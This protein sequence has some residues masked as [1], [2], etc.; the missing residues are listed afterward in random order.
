MENKHTCRFI[1]IGLT[2]LLVAFIVSTCKNPDLPISVSNSSGG[3]FPPPV[4]VLLDTASPAKVFNV[5]DE[6]PPAVILLNATGNPA[7]IIKTEAPIANFTNFGI[8]EGLPSGSI[9]GNIM[10][11]KGQLWFSTGNYV[12]RYDGSGFALLQ[13]GDGSPITDILEDRTGNYWFGSWGGGVYYYDGIFFKN[14]S[15]KD[16]L[17]HNHVFH[18]MEDRKGNVWITTLG[19]GISRFN[20]GR[21]TNYSKKDGLATDM[22]GAIAEDNIGNIW[23]ST[24]GGGLSRFDGTGFT[25]YTRAQGLVD[26]SIYSIHTDRKGNVWFGTQNGISFFD[27]AKFTTVDPGPGL[28]SRNINDIAEDK[29]GKLWFATLGGGV[30]SYDGSG[31][32]ILTTKQGL[33][34]D[35]I[36]SISL[37]R[38]GNV[39]FGSDGGG[40][41]R[42]NGNAFTSFSS[43][44][45]PLTRRIYG[46]SQDSSGN[47]WFASWGNSVTKFDGKNYTHFTSRQGLA[48]RETSSLLQDRNGNIWIGTNG[49]LNRFDGISF[50]TYAK[51]QGLPENP[52]GNVFEDKDG[53]IWFATAGGLCCFFKDTITNYSKA[54]GMAHDYVNVTGQ[55]NNGDMWFGTEGY[56]ISRFDGKSFTTYTKKQ[57]LAGDIVRSMHKDINGNLWFGTT[58]GLSRFDGSRFLSFTTADGLPDNIISAIAEDDDGAI[59][60]GT[61]NGLTSLRFRTGIGDHRSQTAKGAALFKEN[62]DSLSKCQPVWDNFS[63]LTG[64]PLSDLNDRAILITKHRLPYGAKDDTG[65]IWMGCSDEKVVRLDPRYLI[66]DLKKPLPYFKA[67]TVDETSINWYTLT[68]DKIDSTV[69][70]QQDMLVYGKTLTPNSHDTLRKKFRNIQFDS[71]TRFYQLPQ[72]LVLP[73]KHNRVS[74]DYGAVETTRNFMIRYQYMLEGYDKNWSPVTEKTS[75]TYGNIYEGSYTFKLKAK[76]PEGIWGEPIEYTFK[77]LPPLWRTWWFRTI[78]IVCFLGLLYGIYRLRTAALHR[79]KRKLEQTVKDRTAEVVRQKEKSDELLLNILPSEVADELKEKGYT[80]ARAF[81]EVTVLFGDIKGFTHIAEKMSAEE[82]VKEINTYFSAFDHIMMKYKLEK[83]K[84]IGDAYVAASGLRDNNTATASHAVQAALAMQQEV[85]KL[86]A[87]RVAAGKPYFELRIGIH[88]G[89]VIAGVVGIKK[90]QYDIWGDTVNLAARMEQSGVPGKVNISQHSYDLVKDEFLCIH[91]GKIDAKNKG[92]ID[93]YFVENK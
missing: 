22:C 8:N 52:I 64:F 6:H 57:G 63:K 74:I 62:N 65:M 3:A 83:I 60:L 39:W 4:K 79:Q 28:A 85:G 75:V 37:D 69:I 54:Q 2:L 68:K 86:R 84:T 73:N 38:N 32:R 36:L 49:G 71:I 42:F 5:R 23:I 80:T 7:T 48:H 66:K 1:K 21:F 44:Q 87:E 33:A 93:M 53:R 24:F 59:W 77:V 29:D 67:V 34:S 58:G 90:F 43:G 81:D 31:F 51:E 47:L 35:V 92:E 11:R 55:D 15:T 72:G 18:L 78:E 61:Y 19:G 16:G 26:D 76:S 25:T 70:A 88:T 45:S 50:K 17:A 14:Y 40:L 10:D 46:I 89:P 30:C 13:I 12:C 82:L 9:Q 41:S 56:G 27:G 91:R 20:G